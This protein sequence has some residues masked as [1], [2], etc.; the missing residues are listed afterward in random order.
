MSLNILSKVIANRSKY[1][2]DKINARHSYESSY[3]RILNEI[4]SRTDSPRIF[5][6]GFSMEAASVS[7]PTASPMA[8]FLVP[9]SRKPGEE[10][11]LPMQ[12]LSL[13]M[14]IAKRSLTRLRHGLRSWIW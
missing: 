1:N 10:T 2:T 5:E 12:R 6:I 11:S 8:R 7:G 3:E 14:P 13:E 9:M 4:A